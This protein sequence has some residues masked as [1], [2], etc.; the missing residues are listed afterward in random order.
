M[1]FILDHL[2]EIEAA[3]PG[4]AGRINHDKIAAAGH[5]LGGGTVSLLLGMQFLDPDD[6]R[7]KDLSD[8]RV[9]AGV[10]IGAPGI[11]D[12][13][14]S[15]VGSDELPDDEAHRLHKHDRRWSGHRRG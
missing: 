4:L 15:R 5:S 13:H 3:V 8:T 9:K 12:I 7:E 14:L 2:H 6:D 10:M 1:H 11:G